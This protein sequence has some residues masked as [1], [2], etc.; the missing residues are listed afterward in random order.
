MNPVITNFLA[1]CAKQVG[2]HATKIVIATTTAV[3]TY[4]ITSK[5][6]DKA[7]NKL[8]KKHDKELAEKISKEM[9]EKIDELIAD[10]MRF[11]RIA[12]ACRE[13]MFPLLSRVISTS[14]E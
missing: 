3:V 4:I 8:K 5:S 10:F 14:D 13:I 1:N 9:N 2:K 12:S 11:I 6:K 7:Y